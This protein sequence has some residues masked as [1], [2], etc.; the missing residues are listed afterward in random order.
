[1]KSECD[2]TLV[3]DHQR[4]ELRLKNGAKWPMLCRPTDIQRPAGRHLVVALPGFA[5]ILAAVERTIFR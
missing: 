2:R 1:M 3:P 5:D 4:G